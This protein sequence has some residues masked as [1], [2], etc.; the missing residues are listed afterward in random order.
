MNTA[1]LRADDGL[2]TWIAPARTALL[3]VDMQVDFA[4]PD[5]VIGRFGVDLSAVGAA[6]DA[7]GRLVEAARAAGAPVVFVGLETTPQTDAPTLLERMRRRGGDPEIER[8]ICRAGTPGADFYGPVPGPSELVVRKPRYSAFVG[9]D[10]D[11]RL[12][13]RGVDTLVVCGLTTECCV[14]STVRDAFHRDYH[15]FVASDACA[16]YEPDLHEGALKSLG[17]SF[18]LLET[19]SE[20]RAAWGG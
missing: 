3:V 9:T 11:A 6:L 13:A 2:S 4:A 10:L 18:A 14:D 1:P 12:R 17:L 20:I 19:T 8:A 15:V 5:G 16:A 7:A